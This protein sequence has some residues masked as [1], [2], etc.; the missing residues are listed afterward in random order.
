LKKTQKIEI[1]LDTKA[2]EEV[3][4]GT[5]KPV[6]IK[7]KNVTLRSALRHILRPLDLV[8]TIQDEVLLIT[9]PEVIESNLIVEIYPVRD[10]IQYKDDRGRWQEEATELAELIQE[11]VQPNTWDRVGGPGSIPD[12]DGLLVVSQT[13]EI[14]AEI[15]E[16]LAKLRMLPRIDSAEAGKVQSGIRLDQ[17]DRQQEKIDAALKQPIKLTLENQPLGKVVQMLSEQT[18]INILLDE[19]E[20]NDVGITPDTKITQSFNNISLQAA[21]KLLYKAFELSH[22]VQDEA[23][24]I[25]PI[26]ADEQWPVSVAFPVLDLLSLSAEADSAEI[27]DKLDELIDSVS[28]TIEPHTWNSVGGPG[29]IG[30]FLQ[31]GALVVSNTQAIQIEVA[32]LLAKLRKARGEQPVPASDRPNADQ[33]ELIVYELAYLVIQPEEGKPAP[34]QPEHIDTEKL[35]LILPDLIGA[36]DWQTSDKVLAKGL[37]DRLV[38]NQ[39]LRV[40]RKIQTLLSQ[41]GVSFAARNSRT[42]LIHG[43]PSA[44]GGG[45]GFFNLPDK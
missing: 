23:L 40:H 43:L 45:M 9:T 28:R 24:M 37:T 27:S 21:L 3:G 16:L 32:E 30:D 41:M 22:F 14:H 39:T 33:L 36:D 25:V 2:L 6:T 15:A 4:V 29:A 18:G 17:V 35:A 13:Q 20:L 19:S 26:G 38:V 12:Y 42:G 31:R 1:Q 11:F 5:D 34:I 44:T 10:L 8:Y 7:L